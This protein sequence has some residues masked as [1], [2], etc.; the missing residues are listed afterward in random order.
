[1][2]KSEKSES[3]ILIVSAQAPDPIYAVYYIAAD[4]KLSFDEVLYW[5]VTSEPR[6]N[7]FPLV[8]ATAL[9][10]DVKHGLRSAQEAANMVGFWCLLGDGPGVRKVFKD[11]IEMIRKDYAARVAKEPVQ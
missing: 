4:D 9:V 11:E 10:L 8:R 7:Y 5:A 2:M 1:M 3:P 6:K